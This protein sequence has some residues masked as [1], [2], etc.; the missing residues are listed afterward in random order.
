M[1]AAR[2]DIRE[3]WRMQL[4]SLLNG[5][6]VLSEPYMCHNCL[7]TK[8]TGS[9]LLKQSAGYHLLS[10]NQRQ[11]AI[12]YRRRVDPHMMMKQG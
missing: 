6:Y 12:S 10:S 4:I 2:L 11:L 9:Q 8:L 3:M 7:K 1:A 5:G